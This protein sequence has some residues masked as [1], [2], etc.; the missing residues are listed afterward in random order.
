MPT[1]WSGGCW[2]CPELVDH[3]RRPTLSLFQTGVRFVWRLCQ[4]GQLVRFHW[5]LAVLT[6]G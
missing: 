1:V 5:H 3:G 2:P 6:G 4:R